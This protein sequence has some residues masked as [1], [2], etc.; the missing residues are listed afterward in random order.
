MPAFAAL[1]AVSCATK[2]IAP[3]PHLDATTYRFDETKG[4]VRM[5][6]EPIVESERAKQYFGFDARSHRILPVLIEFESHDSAASYRIGPE[7]VALGDAAGRAVTM[8]EV[9]SKTA[10]TLE[11][12]SLLLIPVLGPVAAIASVAASNGAGK[13]RSDASVALHQI[14]VTQLREHTLSPGET[15]RGV[16]F[17]ALDRKRPVPPEL[18]LSVGAADLDG[19]VVQQVEFPIAL[20]GVYE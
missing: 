19:H 18:T 9:G 5:E 1:L 20:A 4:N 6:V 15:E 13:Q 3:L 8:D 2:T 14:A 11:A 16:V 7:W 12:V 17:F 10:G